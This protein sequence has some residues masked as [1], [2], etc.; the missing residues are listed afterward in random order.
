[1]IVLTDELLLNYKRCSRRTYLE[2][3]GSQNK[4]DPQKEFLR[5]LRKENKQHIQSFIQE[6]SLLPQKPPIDSRDW[7]LKSQET[8]ALMKQGVDCIDGGILSLTWQ[9]WDRGINNKALK[10]SILLDLTLASDSNESENIV[11]NI[12]INTST[13]RYFNLNFAPQE[14]ILLAHPTLLIKQPGRSIFGDWTYIPVNI[15]LGRRPKPE[16]KLIG[17]YHAQ[18]LAIIQDE[19]PRQSPLILRQQNEYQISLN[20]WLDRT[21][22]IVAN[23]LEML[24]QQV[25]PEVFISRQKCNLCHWYSHCYEQA[26]RKKHLSLVP[27]IT[28]K[29]YESLKDIGLDNLELIASSSDRVLEKRIGQDV[30]KQLRQQARA[31]LLNTALIK[32]DYNLE[33][34]YQLPSAAIELYF[35][36]EAEPDRNLDYLLGI[37]VVDNINNTQ[38]FFPFLAERVDEEEKVWREFF[39]FMMQYPHAPIFHFSG[40]EVDTIKRLA[41]LYETPKLPT[42]A[43]LSR[44]VDIHHWV[45]KS[46]I[47]PVESYSL[48]S[49]ANWLGF[50]WREETASGDQSVCW[51]DSWLTTEDRSLLDAIL[52]YNEDDCYATYYLK[53]WLAKFFL[54]AQKQQAL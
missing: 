12:V 41:K 26:K 13:S 39:D 35:D 34:T 4:K 5:K 51:Y 14:I 32:T 37:L 25:E 11:E 43:L 22:D 47:L 27:G 49:L 6:R 2:V 31:I 7:R 29:R 36:I 8:L 54:E 19:F 18:V 28:P 52:N 15:K 30:A 1:M 46:V 48:K 10:P 9:D 3:Y 24:C 50:Q 20:H 53:D 38:E 45:T 42:K 40:Y 17:A 21:K 16:Y 33:Q 23:C 44:C